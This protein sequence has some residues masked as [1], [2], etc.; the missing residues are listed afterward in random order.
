MAFPIV[1]HLYAASR[2]IRRL[3]RT[4]IFKE[5]DDKPGDILIISY[6][7]AFLADVTNHLATALQDLPSEARARYRDKRLRWRLVFISRTD[8][9]SFTGDPHRGTTAFTRSR[10]GEVIFWDPKVID[11]YKHRSTDVSTRFLYAVHN[12]PSRPARLYKAKECEQNNQDKICYNRNLHGHTV[13][14]YPQPR[15]VN[16]RTYNICSDAGHFAKDCPNKDREGA[17]T[18]RNCENVGHIAKDHL[19]VSRARQN[20]NVVGHSS[21]ERP[22][23]VRRNCGLSLLCPIIT[24][25]ITLSMPVPIGFSPQ[26]ELLREIT[27]RL[28]P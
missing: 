1:Q 18:C 14:D 21:K 6:F 10:Y 20:C 22:G 27:K 17:K 24:T 26:P 11:Q 9:I 25:R 16:N 4:R 28:L 13:K 2:T 5:A 8:A 7:A 12:L 23:F 15:P 3:L 19:E